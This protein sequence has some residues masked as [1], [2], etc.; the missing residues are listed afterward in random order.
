MDGLIV[1]VCIYACMYGWM[2]RY[3]N[4]CLGDWINVLTDFCVIVCMIAWLSH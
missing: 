3:V 4:G 2:E 1:D